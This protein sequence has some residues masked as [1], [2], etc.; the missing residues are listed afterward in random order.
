MPRLMSANDACTRLRNS[1]AAADNWRF[2]MTQS[3]SVRDLMTLSDSLV[4]VS[5]PERTSFMT[6]SQLKIATPTL[7]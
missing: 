1:A 7:C 6:S 3:D 5:S 2:G 4:K